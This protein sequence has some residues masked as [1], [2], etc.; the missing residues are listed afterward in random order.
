MFTWEQFAASDPELAVLGQGQLFQFGVGLAF[1]ATVRQDG[2][3]RLHPVCPVLT[4][5]HLYVFVPPASPKHAD[6][7]RDGRFAIQA[8]P[9][10]K[11]ESEEFYLSGIAV[12][13]QDP[14]LWKK[15]AKATVSRVSEGETLFELKLERAMYTAW[16]NWGTS[17]VHPVHHKWK[18]PDQG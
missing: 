1:L 13:I 6:L 7:L 17:D 11:E 18:A 12:R 5:G 16:E 15:A 4:D 3:P 2:G 10:P 14:V 8:F 9:P